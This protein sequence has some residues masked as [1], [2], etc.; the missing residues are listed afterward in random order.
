MNTPHCC[1]RELRTIRSVLNNCRRGS[2]T[3]PEPAGEDA[4]ATRRTAITS[5]AVDSRDAC[6]QR[7]W[8]RR[9]REAAGWILPGAVLALMPKCPMCL[10][11]YV[12]LCSGLTMSCSSAHL[13]MRLLTALC[14]GT[15]AL[16]VVRRVVNSRQ[17]KPTLNLEPTQT[18]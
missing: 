3:L 15:L 9:A 7:T 18:R 6:Q 14:I 13:L 5:D 1:Q 17:S 10:V 4:R 11:A 16:C 12:A 2:E 8:R